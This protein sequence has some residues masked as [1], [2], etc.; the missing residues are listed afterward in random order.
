MYSHNDF[1]INPEREFTQ[2]SHG[3]SRDHMR[4]LQSRLSHQAGCAGKH[5][6]VPAV[7]PVLP[8]SISP[9]KRINSPC[10]MHISAQTLPS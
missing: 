9:S 6:V 10:G 8:L 5:P 7:V 3:G 1:N 4:N 2:Q